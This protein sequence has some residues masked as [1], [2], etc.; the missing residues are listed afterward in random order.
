M[1]IFNLPDLGEGLPD[2]EIHE[3]HVKEGDT[4][5]V[6]QLLVSM[7]T[8][9]AVVDVPA[10]QGGRIVKLH[11]QAGDVISTGSP[12]VEF[13]EGEAKAAQQPQAPQAA[14]PQAPQ[15]PQTQTPSVR[16][17]ANLA[18]ADMSV[19]ET[20][21]ETASRVVAETP[22]ATAQSS[23]PATEAPKG[24]TVAGSIEVGNTVLKE[25]PTGIAPKPTDSGGEQLR[26]LPAV[27][28]LANRLRV[29]LNT[30]KGSGP[31]GL[32]TLED[33]K[34]AAGNA[35]STPREPVDN[36]IPEQTIG[37]KQP[38]RGVRRS[39]AQAMIL[40]HQEVVP[41]T[42]VEDADL[43]AWREGT[44]ITIRIL[45]ALAKACLAEPSLNAVFDGKTLSRE[46]K[47]TVNVGIAMDSSEGLFVPVIKD[48][49]NTTPED[50]RYTIN[51]FKDQVSNRTI[52]QEDLQGATISLSNFGTFAGRYAN[53]I[54]VPPCVAILGTGRMREEFIPVN[55]QPEIHRI[56]PLSLT[57]DHRAATGGEASRFLG[58]VIKDLQLVD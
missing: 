10:P 31:N 18:A 7:E 27:R 32:I 39:M 49:A 14:E 44:D 57:F 6:D 54:V 36:P 55:G 52:P 22:T 9:K 8:A 4:V 35:V 3:W 26:V 30:L 56:L 45:R 53:P 12:L 29:D 38:L 42:L 46:L 17:A 33:V 5:E 2:A 37:D 21:P 43:H 25:S 51:R 58:E 11:G 24:A 50:L 48:I 13:A 23:E 28:N 19:P 1:S 40:S 20:K 47:Q 16:E 15:K 41:V 34:N